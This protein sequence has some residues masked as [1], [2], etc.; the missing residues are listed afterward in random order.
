MVRR[1]GLDA[2]RLCRGLSDPLAILALMFERRPT[3]ADVHAARQRGEYTPAMPLRA[4]DVAAELRG[5]LPGL[6]AKKLHKLL[7]YSQGHHLAATGE[8]LFD[9]TLSAWDMGPVVGRLWRQERDGV[10]REERR[11]L[12]EG[13]LNTVGYVVS[14]Y[15][16]LSGKDLE[17]LTHAE[18]PWQRANLRRAPGE[19]VRI[20]LQWIREYF[21]SATSE[22]L[23]D[24]GLLDAEVV[25][26]WL[27]PAEDRRA[28]ELA[29]DSYEAIRSRLRDAG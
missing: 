20:E 4:H 22:E 25:S 12:T 3:D 8:A 26:A 24:D 5:R 17:H 15:G 11:T 18:T 10:L 28:E 13:Q 23:E 9:D 7:Y 16:Q 29:T 19:S 14:R 27:G 2:A 1:D 6:P 21:E